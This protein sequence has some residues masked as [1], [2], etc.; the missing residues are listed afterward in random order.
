[1]PPRNLPPNNQAPAQGSGSSSTTVPQ[2]PQ[3][4]SPEPAS[5]PDSSFPRTKIILRQSKRDDSSQGPSDEDLQGSVRTSSPRTSVSRATRRKK[6]TGTSRNNRVL[7]QAA[8]SD[9]SQIAAP[10]SQL[11]SDQKAKRPTKVMNRPRT[12]RSTATRDGVRDSGESELE[13][14]KAQVREGLLE[15]K[16]HQDRARELGIQIVALEEDIKSKG[17][18]KF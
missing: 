7:G 18:S 4:A 14:V 9:S 5:R 10:S 13:A 16:K 17:S 6:S 15:A 12:G 11:N 3:P 1:M 8:I 2:T